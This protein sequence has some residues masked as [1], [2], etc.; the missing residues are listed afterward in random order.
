MPLAG[1]INA[2]AAGHRVSL[3]GLFSILR[4][5]PEGGRLAQAAIAIHLV[6]QYFVISL[7]PFVSRTP[8]CMARSTA[9]VC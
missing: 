8:S 2:A 9:T 5:I 1:Y 6:G 7:S 3:F 4:L